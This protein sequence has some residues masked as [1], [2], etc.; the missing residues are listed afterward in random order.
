MTFLKKLGSILAKGLA[1]AT[2]IWPIVQGFFGSSTSPVV[3]GA[4][5]YVPT[6]INDLTQI[7]GIV[8]QVEAIIQTPGSGADKLKAATPLVANVVRTSELISGKKI[9][10]DTL[11]IQGCGKLTDGMADILNSLH[12]DAAQT[13]PTP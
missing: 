11:F 10:N 6:I 9:A 2:G 12:P 8:V 3:H 13:A 7:A 5:E 1:M 4:V